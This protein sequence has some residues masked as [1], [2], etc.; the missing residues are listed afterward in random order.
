[1]GFGGET[2]HD[3]NRQCI[4]YECRN[5]THIQCFAQHLNLASQKALQLPAVEW[6]LSRIRLVT[7]FFRCSTIASHQLKHKQDLLQLPKHRLITDVVTKWNSSHDIRFLEQLA[8]YAALLSTEVRKSEKDVFTPNETDITCAE[9]VLKAL[10]PMK[11]ATLV[12]PLVISHSVMGN[13]KRSSYK[14]NYSLL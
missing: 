8:I 14:C 10:K 6:L 13:N 3:C 9:E 2:S 4:H 12:M 1:M 11:N 5:M 7:S